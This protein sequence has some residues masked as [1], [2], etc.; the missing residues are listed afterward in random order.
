MSLVERCGRTFVVALLRRRGC[1]RYPRRRRRAVLR[2]RT[3]DRSTAPLAA[4]KPRT[5]RRPRRDCGRCGGCGRTWRGTEGR[6]TK[7]EGEGGNVWG[8]RFG[9]R[10]GAVA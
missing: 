5:P 4:D 10:A 3:R 1:W 2:A 8:L 9:G 6:I 7:D